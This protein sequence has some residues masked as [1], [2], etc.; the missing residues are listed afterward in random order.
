M[1]RM[2]PIVPMLTA[3]CALSSCAHTT[4]N[5]PTSYGNEQVR[6]ALIENGVEV[7]WHR[8]QFD[9]DP[10]CDPELHGDWVL[11]PG[12]PDQPAALFERDGGHLVWAA[13]TNGGASC[14]VMRAGLVA[15]VSDKDRDGRDVANVVV[16]DPFS[17]E[18]RCRFGHGANLRDTAFTGSHVGWSAHD[19]GTKRYTLDGA[20]IDDCAPTWHREV[21]SES[22]ELLTAG[23]VLLLDDGIV[24][25]QTTQHHLERLDPSSGKTLWRVPS[26][27]AWFA[28]RVDDKLIVSSA[29]RIDV[30]WVAT[31]ELVSTMA[32]VDKPISVATRPDLVAVDTVMD[33]FVYA[34]LTGLEMK[35]GRHESFWDGHSALLEEP[36][37]LLAALTT[38][39]RITP[40]AE[41]SAAVIGPKATLAEDGLYSPFGRVMPNQTVRVLPETR[42]GELFA[43][44]LATHPV[45]LNMASFALVLLADTWMFECHHQGWGMQY[46]FDL[47]PEQPYRMRLTPVPDCRYRQ[48]N[49]PEAAI[50]VVRK[51]LTEEGIEEMDCKVRFPEEL[52]KPFR[53]AVVN[54][55]ANHP[56]IHKQHELEGGKAWFGTAA[57]ELI[58]WTWSG[59]GDGL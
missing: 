9:D 21:Q 18:T 1:P 24:D 15:Y 17:G 54:A 19:Y 31:G 29:K 20:A 7:V 28:A 23:E 16:A 41:L 42:D 59:F 55:P 22:A 38:T 13:P 40:L 14:A 51:P 35:L 8:E 45:T 39:G 50:P 53:V 10:E 12:D 33:H 36:K 30:R 3:V 43:T 34:P 52:Q 57:S 56:R 11:M 46:D 27:G 4:P 5:G 44:L 58:T 26:A 25:A 37:F 32:L 48:G 49:C 47:T 2:Q 6:R